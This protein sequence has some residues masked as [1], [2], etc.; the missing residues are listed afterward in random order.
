MNS[1]LLRRLRWLWFVAVLG[2]FAL[3]LAACGGA[4]IGTPT[5]IPANIVRPEQPTPVY[6]TAQPRF[7]LDQATGT[8]V[9]VA[10]LAAAA[11]S[12]ANADQLR[13]ELLKAMLMNLPP[14]AMGIA[15]GGATIYAEPGGAVAGSVPAGGTITVTGRSH[16]GNWLAVYTNEA[17]TGWVAA[18]A[19]R[20]FGADDLEIVE[21]ALSPAPV[22][23]MLAEA[24]QPVALSMS[25]VIATRA[26]APATRPPAT[27][28]PAE[29]MIVAPQGVPL[30]ATVQIQG[31]LNLRQA[32]TSDSAIVASLPGG[33]QVI[34]L[35]RT[36][37][38]EWL[39]VRTP[40][41]DGWVNA[42]FV[43]LDGD[44]GSL[45]VAEQ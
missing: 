35:G 1:M 37:T 5:P 19:L 43:A 27:P 15:P 29:S 14:S 41:G 9:F 26:A 3:L 17:I 30:L 8:P 24:M 23:T 21:T 32:P 20:L 22:A 11:P 6:S 28:A 12:P 44:M 38:G 34:A 33:S 39:Q 16:D 40:A 42:G 18:G 31:N 7:R 10:S 36:E 45:P 4:A 25:D 2:L 13:A